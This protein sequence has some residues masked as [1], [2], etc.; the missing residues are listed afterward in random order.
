M[1]SNL[2][3]VK[4]KRG[5]ERYHHGALREALLAAAEAL[6]RERGLDGFS[7]REAAR[8]VGVSPA[9]P[10]HHFGDAR[11]L[12]T[13]VATAGFQELADAL[14]AA[15]SAAGPERHARIRAQGVAYVG[16][17]LSQPARF[18]VMWRRAR[19]DCDDPAYAAASRR[20]FATLAA[21]VAD[22]AEADAPAAP[23]S[24]ADP[25]VLACWSIVHGFARLALDGVFGS[26][27]PA[28]RAAADALLPAVLD[29]VHV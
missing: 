17:A 3:T 26:G 27:A 6:I 24:E 16:F 9:A 23:P 28:A 15:D 10:Q 19:V 25:R 20:A 11:G 21:V 29:C 5:A 8:R 1:A 2:N 4:T 14:A 22:V 12:L 18:D 7:L 13:A